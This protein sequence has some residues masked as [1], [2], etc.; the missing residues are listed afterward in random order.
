MLQYLVDDYLEGYGLPQPRK[1]AGNIGLGVTEE[2]DCCLISMT[3]NKPTGLSLPAEVLA[4]R[5]CSWPVAGFKTY[6]LFLDMTECWMCERQH[7]ESVS[8]ETL[9][10]YLESSE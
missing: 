7:R 2:G 8:P 9:Q 3:N 6:L 4:V 1:V 5:L 10:L